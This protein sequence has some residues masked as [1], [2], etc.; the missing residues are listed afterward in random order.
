MKVLLLSTYENGGG[1]A[2]AASRLL[3]A[4]R[5]NGVDASMLCRTN[6]EY[7]PKR[8]RKQSWA[9]IRERIEI[10]LCNGLNMKTL[11]ATDTASYGQDVTT[12]QEFRE[13]DVIHLH[14]TNQGF[15]SLSE[16]EK[17]MDSGKRIVI[18][19]HDDWYFTA[20]CH[21]AGGC[22]GYEHDCSS[23]CL[24]KSSKAQA[25]MQRKQSLYDSRHFTLTS[26]SNWLAGRAAK[27]SLMKG[28]DIH[29]VP[30]M[31]P[32]ENYGQ[33]DKAACRESL[34]IPQEAKVISFCAAKID[35]PVKDL[36]KLIN[37]VERLLMLHPEWKSDMQVRLIGEAKDHT[38]VRTLPHTF[39]Y[40]GRVG[41]AM[42][43]EEFGAADVIA[44]TSVSETFGQTLIEA[45]AS[46]AL[47]V[48]FANGG[49]TDIIYHKQNGYLTDERSAEAFAK[50][51]EWAFT[52]GS[53]HS[54]TALHDEAVRRF[55]PQAVAK[56]YIELYD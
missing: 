2:V 20:V 16:L 47:P 38:T 43:E 18:T 34:G 5:Q 19:M 54:R 37:A 21:V 33:T 11:W 50:G 41:A 36:P 42:L 48:S 10:L 30:N 6:I 53:K 17:I 3:Q 13:A 52:E 27:S 51:L 1:A 44:C 55:S 12:T 4:L 29:V 49:Q 28:R 23:C 8:L 9:S 15:L 22:T 56:M 32:R 24:V 40:I 14:W 39:I 45:Q 46:G 25:I 31:L 7:G 35:D 26:V